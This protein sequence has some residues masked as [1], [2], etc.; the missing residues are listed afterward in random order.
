MREKR[1]AIMFRQKTHPLDR[2]LRRTENGRIFVEPGARESGFTLLEIVIVLTIIGFLLAMIAPRLGNIGTSAVD[3]IDDSNI[4]D[5][6]GYV[7][8]YQ[9]KKNR[10]PNKP[11]TI[12]NSSAG[13]GYQMPLI[14][15][16]DADN[17]PE[18]IG[19]DFHRRCKLELH[20]LNKEEAEEIKKMGIRRFVVLNDYKG[21]TNSDFIKDGENSDLK[22]QTFATGDAGRPFHIVD[23]D[24][25]VGVLMIGAGADGK[26]SKVKAEVS[27]GDEVGN[28]DWMYRIVLGLGSD[29]SLV[30]D[31]M[32]Q[33]EGL[34]PRGMQNADYNTFNNYTMVLPRL[35]ATLDRIGGGAPKQITGGNAKY[36][37]DDEKA[38]QK[39][40]DL[41]QAQELWE[42]EVCSPLGY[43][44]PQD[45][46]E[47]WQ[48]VDI[49]EKF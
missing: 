30:S 38:I 17:G 5:M 44:W 1:R 7:M 43:K 39:L 3:T 36:D 15:D 18:T 14:D 37:E 48:V 47:M 32:V 45:E 9:Q 35:Q 13:K 10:L 19:Y 6:R 24:E 41:N 25:G 2:P 34:S 49:E 22:P 20:I 8:L 46:V 27:E 21:S 42:V 23:V 26:D 33:N 40:Y 28:P 31:G 4:K 12:V 11:I 16:G 29:S